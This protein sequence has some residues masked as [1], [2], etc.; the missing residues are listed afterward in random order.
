[1]DDEFRTVQ[2][3]DVTALAELLATLDAKEPTV[4][5]APDGTR[6]YVLSEAAHERLLDKLEDARDRLACCIAREENEPTIPFEDVLREH[7]PER[8]THVAD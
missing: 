5:V 1:M 6:A 8:Y 2:T 3:D 7:M 4:L